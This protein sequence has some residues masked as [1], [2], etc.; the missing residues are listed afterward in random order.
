[1]ALGIF[2]VECLHGFQ[3]FARGG[4][5]IVCHCCVQSHFNAPDYLQ[6]LED[7]VV[8][9]SVPALHQKVHSALKRGSLHQKSRKRHLEKTNYRYFYSL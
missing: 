9:L 4:M 8:P 1:M 7:I 5:T 3:K 6:C 2:G